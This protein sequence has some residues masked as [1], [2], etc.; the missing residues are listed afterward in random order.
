MVSAPIR[1]SVNDRLGRLEV[2]DSLW[3]ETTLEGYAS[4]M[5]QLVPAASRRTGRLK[6]R[7]FTASLFTAV[8][9]SKAGVILYLIRTVRTK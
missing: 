1:Y 2:G 6:G 4:K 8:S 5:R 3:T 9:A 7:E